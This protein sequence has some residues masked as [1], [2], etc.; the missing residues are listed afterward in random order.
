METEAELSRYKDNVV[1][2]FPRVTACKMRIDTSIGHYKK[3]EKSLDGKIYNITISEV[4][5]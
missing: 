3:F 2:E 1:A 4:K 5:E